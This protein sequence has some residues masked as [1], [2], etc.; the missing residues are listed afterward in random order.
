MLPY[1]YLN[2]GL[3]VTRRFVKRFL[4]LATDWW[5]Q[6]FKEPASLS[7][8]CWYSFHSAGKRAHCTLS[9]ATNSP[10]SYTCSQKV[11]ILFASSKEKL[12]L[13]VKS[14]AFWK[15]ERVRAIEL[16]GRFSGLGERERERKKGYEPVWTNFILFTFYFVTF[17][18]LICTVSGKCCEGRRGSSNESCHQLYWP[19]RQG[20]GLYS[21][22]QT[23]HQKRC[24]YRH[25]LQRG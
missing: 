10:N 2:P 4:F 6:R 25:H 15:R 19:G 7:T 14:A 22:N 11:L 5:S 8:P 12:S 20:C 17:S 24:C 13:F 9:S 3:T 21:V 1:F 23:P 16:A 18:P